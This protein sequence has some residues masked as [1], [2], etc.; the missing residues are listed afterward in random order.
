MSFSQYNL[1]LDKSSNAEDIWWKAI[2]DPKTTELV[3]NGFAQSIFVTDKM[4]EKLSESEYY[5]VVYTVAGHF[6]T[7]ISAIEKILKKWSKYEKIRG[8]I[9]FNSTVTA[10]MHSYIYEIGNVSDA[11]GIAYFC[12]TEL[13]I[14]EKIFYD[15]SRF[16]R[17][18]YLTIVLYLAQNPNCSEN[19]LLEMY[20]IR[21]PYI[22]QHIAGNNNCPVSL[23]VPLAKLKNCY[24]NQELVKFDKCP[25]MALRLM[26]NCLNSSEYVKNK[27]LTHP[28]CPMDIKIINILEN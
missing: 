1:M 20:K 7:P 6:R 24:I 18:D 4:L 15:K 21:S 17:R 8:R 12:K 26:Y 22:R 3:L 16:K 23:F 28:N 11:I 5:S 10:D 27:V 19:L 14:L 2:N 13:K 9:I 25:E